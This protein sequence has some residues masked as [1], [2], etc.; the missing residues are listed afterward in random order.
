MRIQLPQLLWYGNTTLEIDLPDQWEVQ[1]CP[2]R[3]AGRPPMS[4]AQMETAILD[5]IGSP[6]I[7]DIAK[8]KRTAVIVFDDM[9]RPTQDL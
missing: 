6:P 1:L 5:P 9:T 3:G 7:R 4:L 8:G 2:M